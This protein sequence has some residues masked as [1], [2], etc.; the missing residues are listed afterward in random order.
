MS[1][2]SQAQFETCQF[3]QPT[4]QPEEADDSHFTYEA[5]EARAV[6]KL[7]T[8]THLQSKDL[9]PV[10]FATVPMLFT[11]PYAAS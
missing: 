4:E 1:A 2:L 10:S 8:R 9:N 3:I 6:K 5:A 11:L 7:T